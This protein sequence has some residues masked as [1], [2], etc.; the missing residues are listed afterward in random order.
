MKQ[1]QKKK[2]KSFFFFFGKY[3]RYVC[4][5]IFNQKKAFSAR[6]PFFFWKIGI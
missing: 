3:G 2:E 5:S 6:I 1:K 4:I